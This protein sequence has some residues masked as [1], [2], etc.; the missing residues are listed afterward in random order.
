ME[1]HHRGLLLPVTWLGAHRLLYPSKEV[2]GPLCL[3]FAIGHLLH[4]DVSHDR[5]L[6]GKNLGRP[7]P[8][9]K[10]RRAAALLHQG[11][12]VG[13][14]LLVEPMHVDRRVVSV[15]FRAAVGCVG[16]LG[17]FHHKQRLVHLGLVS[18]ERQHIPDFLPAL[19]FLALLEH[20]H[21]FLFCLG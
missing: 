4:L 17:L 2:V 3:G 1:L 12:V 5:P 14:G 18:F 11:H 16:L 19:L 8:V 9:V 15:D 13:I 20:S 7:S 21:L 6:V 10:S